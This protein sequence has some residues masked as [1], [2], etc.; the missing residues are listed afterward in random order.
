MRITLLIGAA[1]AFIASG[2]M[3]QT[4]PA[5]DGPQNSAVNTQ[6]FDNRMVD[7]S[8]QGANSFTEGEAQVPHREARFR[9][10]QRLKKDETG[11]GAARR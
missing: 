6:Q 9:E 1:L 2:A 5:K 7:R 4:P 11:S 3:A 8:G 10:C